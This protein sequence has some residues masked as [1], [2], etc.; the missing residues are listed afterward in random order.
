MKK[1]DFEVV[2]RE[3]ERGDAKE[4]VDFYNVVG[5]ETTYL[6]FE[7]DEYPMNYE[8]QAADIDSVRE[9]PNCTMLLALVD[10]RIVGIG[11]ISSTHKVKG[12]HV[13]ELG[14]VV[15]QKYQAY[16]IGTE[17]M[18]KLI[19]YCRDNG[20]TTKITLVTRRDNVNA[21]KLYERLGFRIEGTLTDMDF[22]DGEYHDLYSMGRRV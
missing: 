4:I 8:Q 20:V 9:S 21:V 1:R 18:E 22:S 19:D 14:I 5:G 15:T 17:I 13:G 16:G 12:R 7:K 6:S 10:N 3:P 11:T 2:Y